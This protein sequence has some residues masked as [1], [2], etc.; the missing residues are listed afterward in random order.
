MSHYA[1]KD[2]EETMKLK[3]MRDEF[4]SQ[5]RKLSIEKADQDKLW[6]EKELELDE[7]RTEIGLL[8]TD[9]ASKE[10]ELEALKKE[11]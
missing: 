6:K 2:N 7:A 10:K 11:M 8:R 1:A 5:L 9:V 4:E 3:A